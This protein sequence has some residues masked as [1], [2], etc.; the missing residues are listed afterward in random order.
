MKQSSPYQIISH[1]NYD[2]SPISLT[3]EFP[4]KYILSEPVSVAEYEE[5]DPFS[6]MVAAALENNDLNTVNLVYIAI[7]KVEASDD[8]NDVIQ[9]EEAEKLT[10]ESEEVS[11]ACMVIIQ[12][13]S[14]IHAEKT[15]GRVS[16]PDKPNYPSK[17]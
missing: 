4:A 14:M 3:I 17:S 8:G 15:K 2:D 16:Y 11:N 12:G 6:D 5:G 9:I 13:T 7:I 10:S 1:E